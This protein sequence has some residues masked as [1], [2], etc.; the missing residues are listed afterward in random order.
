MGIS[1][2]V[3]DEVTVGRRIVNVSHI[4]SNDIGMIENEAN[5]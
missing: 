4:I 3:K 2:K 1:L 5:K